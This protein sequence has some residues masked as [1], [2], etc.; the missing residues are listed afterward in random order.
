MTDLDN[1]RKAFEEAYLSVGGKQRDLELEDGEY[2]NS[3]SQLGWE[4]W[5]IKSKDQAVPDQTINEIQSWIAVQSTQAM[6]LDGEA[7]VVGANELAEFIEQL[8]K[9][10]SG[11]KQP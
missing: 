5:Q 8:V 9:G 1:E 11:A 10:E 7:F 2:T 6:E 3:K 4:L